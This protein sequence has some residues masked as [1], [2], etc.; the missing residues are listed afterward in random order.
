VVKSLV[1]PEVGGTRA[2]VAEF[3]QAARS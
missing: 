2:E 1:F 3:S